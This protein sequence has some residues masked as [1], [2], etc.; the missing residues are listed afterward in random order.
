M[1]AVYGFEVGSSSPEDEDPRRLR[2]EVTELL[3]KGYAPVVVW[4]SL[5]HG[6]FPEPDLRFGV[7]ERLPIYI[8]IIR[9]AHVVVSV[10]DVR[11]SRTQAMLDAVAEDAGI[12]LADLPPHGGCPVSGG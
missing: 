2:L 8:S 6:S 10:G 3:R 5:P 7:P 4:Q 12:R 9:R 1:V 11:G